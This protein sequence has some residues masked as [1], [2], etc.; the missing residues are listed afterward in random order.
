M[1]LESLS[2]VSRFYT[3]CALSE[4]FK[5]YVANTDDASMMFFPA[6]SRGRMRAA[7]D[8]DCTDILNDLGGMAGAW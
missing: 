6:D 1:S 8:R 3:V 7:Y 2:S 5:G 4:A